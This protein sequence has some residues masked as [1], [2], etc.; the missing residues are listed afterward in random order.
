[1]RPGDPALAGV[2]LYHQW[3]VVDAGATGGLTASA[4]HGGPLHRRP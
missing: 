2:P 4:G 1:M 3:L